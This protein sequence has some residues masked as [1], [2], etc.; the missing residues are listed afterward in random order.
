MRR[1]LGVESE[2][3]FQETYARN[4]YSETLDPENLKLIYIDNKKDSKPEF[5]FV[6]SSKPVIFLE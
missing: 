6:E 1:L 2:F 3:F 5:V 4:F